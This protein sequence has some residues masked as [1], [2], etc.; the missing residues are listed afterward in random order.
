MPKTPEGKGIGT[1]VRSQ[2]ATEQAALRVDVYVLLVWPRYAED[3]AAFVC[4][5]NEASEAQPP[6]DVHTD[7]RVHSNH[8]ESLYA[9]L[10][11]AQE[12]WNPVAL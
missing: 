8:V 10:S 11:V 4:S 6:I 3:L 1:M 9:D 12:S 5:T 2:W 7:G